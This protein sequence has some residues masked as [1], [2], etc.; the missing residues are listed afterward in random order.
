MQ[1]DIVEVQQVEKNSCRR[2]ACNRREGIISSWEASAANGEYFI[3]P[4]C[5][6]AAS[7]PAYNPPLR[8]VKVPPH[9]ANIQNAKHW[10]RKALN[11]ITDCV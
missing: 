3:L 7:I 5:P 9:E 1:G 10:N 4:A 6:F 8:I 11:I 2:G